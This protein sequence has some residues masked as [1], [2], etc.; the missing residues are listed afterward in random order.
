MTVVKPRSAASDTAEH[1]SSSIPW[2]YAAIT[3]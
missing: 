1:F 2:M 3:P